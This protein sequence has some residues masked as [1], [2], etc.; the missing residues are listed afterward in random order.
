MAAIALGWLS[1]IRWRWLTTA[2]VLT[3]PFY[4]LHQKIGWTLIHGVRD[5][6]PRYVILPAVLVIMLTA[7]W[8]LHRLVEKPL[9]RYLRNKLAP[10]RPPQ[11]P[12]TARIPSPRTELV[13]SATNA[14]G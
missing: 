6:A 4:L 5:F 13:P 8:L 9:A 7:A 14:G 12:P 11:P 2:G 1:W 3:Y 10:P